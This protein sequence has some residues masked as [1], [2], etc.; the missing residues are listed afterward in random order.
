MSRSG[1]NV[2]VHPFSVVFFLNKQTSVR[3]PPLR[4]DFSLHSLAVTVGDG[5][6]GH[7]CRLPPSLRESRKAQAKPLLLPPSPCDSAELSEWAEREKESSF[8]SF[9]FPLSLSSFSI[10]RSRS[11]S[12]SASL[13]PIVCCVC[14]RGCLSSLSLSPS[15]GFLAGGKIR[16]ERERESKRAP[17]GV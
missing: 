4:T 2:H 11:S 12:S 14:V 16:K 7:Y 17:G 6:G 15:P 3:I 10:G 1:K 13:W 9:P 5:S 8:L